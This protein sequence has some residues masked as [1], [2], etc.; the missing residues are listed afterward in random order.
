MTQKVKLLDQVRAVARA[1]HLSHRTEDTYHNFIKRFI[2]FHN[3]RHPNEM[4]ADEITA[5]LTDL[6]VNIIM[7]FARFRN[8]LGTRMCGRRRFTLTF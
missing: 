6:A 8:C 1:R 4:G 2:L 7:T 5:F 3:K